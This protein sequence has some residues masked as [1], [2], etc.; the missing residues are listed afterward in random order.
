MKFSKTKR[1]VKII[2]ISSYDMY[3]TVSKNRD[4]KE[5]VN[6]KYEN[7][8]NDYSNYADF[9]IPNHYFGRKKT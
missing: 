9:I 6:I 3:Y 5:I 8:E 1:Q 2:N 7:N 4:E